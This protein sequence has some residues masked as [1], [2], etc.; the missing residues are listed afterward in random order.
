[1]SG[2]RKLDKSS[3]GSRLESIEHILPKVERRTP[4]WDAIWNDDYV[5][6]NAR[7]RLGNLVL[8]KDPRSNSKLGQKIN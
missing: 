7:H 5:F 1:M 4:Y 3:K 2:L 8:T 6:E